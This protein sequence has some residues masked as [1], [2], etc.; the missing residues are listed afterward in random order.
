LYKDG[1]GLEHAGDRHPIITADPE[2]VT[3]DDDPDDDP[4]G[5]IVTDKPLAA[6]RNDDP[7]LDDDHLHTLSGG[8][9]PAVNPHEDRHCRQCDGP[10]DGKERAY[11]VDGKP[12]WLHPECRRFYVQRVYR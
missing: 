12:V 4:H 11:T 5:G 3:L 10:V 6:N 9:S 2:I 1:N 8:R 7:C